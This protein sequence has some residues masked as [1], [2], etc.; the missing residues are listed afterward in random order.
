MSGNGVQ[1]ADVNCDACRRWADDCNGC[2]CL[3][4]RRSLTLGEPVSEID[5]GVVQLSVIMS[6]QNL[7]WTEIIMFHRMLSILLVGAALFGPSVCCCTMKV[8]SAGSSAPSC[9]C[10]RQDDSAKQCPENSGGKREHECPCRKHQTV[11][12]RLDDSLILPTSRSVKRVI[13]RSDICLPVLFCQA[14]G[15]S[16]RGTRHQPGS[17]VPIQAGRALL[18]AHG[19]SRC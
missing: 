18:I 13:E 5:L 7:H 10:C 8:A 1:S 14:D 11:G 2:C 15:M 19:V 12:V 16:S 3:A 4:G 9:C 17:C 6:A